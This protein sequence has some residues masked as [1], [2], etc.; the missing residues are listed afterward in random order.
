MVFFTCFVQGTTIKFFVKLMKISLRSEKEVSGRLVKEIQD[1][2]M[3]HVMA[4]IES[5]TGNLGYNTAV[6]KIAAAD[7]KYVS[8]HLKPRD[9]SNRQE[10]LERHLQN[11]ILEDHFT[12][13]YGPQI[14]ASVRLSCWDSESFPRCMILRLVLENNRKN[15]YHLTMFPPGGSLWGNPN[16]LIS[17]TRLGLKLT[18]EIRWQSSKRISGRWWTR[19]WRT[20]TSGRWA[21]PWRGSPSESGTVSWMWPTWGHPSSFS[22]M[23]KF[24]R[25]KNE[26]ILLYSLHKGE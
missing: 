14:I 5:V 21:G 12:S 7:L 4:G 2:L 19:S 9:L 11:S 3:D 15:K 24:R 8:P 17:S 23:T 1:D 16:L 22:S 6:G 13:L 25:R 20:R 10:P 18:S 26:G